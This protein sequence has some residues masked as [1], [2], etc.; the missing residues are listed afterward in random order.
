M[1]AQSFSGKLGGLLRGDKIIWIIVL[2]LSVFSVLTVYSSTE[3][4]AHRNNL[5]A[6]SFLFKHI[7]LL[8]LSIALMF[9]SHIVDHTRYARMSTYMILIAF[10]LLLITVFLGTSINQAAR[11]IRIPIIGLTFQ[12]SDFARLA[13]IVYT[14][15]TVA[16][17]QDES[18]PS[19]LG[20]LVIPVMLV[21][22]LIA[23]ADLSTSMILFFTCLLLMFIGRIEL[24]H[25]FSVLMLGI[26]AFALMISLANYFPAIR[27]DTWV[28]RLRGFVMGN[29]ETNEFASATSSYQVEQAQMAIAQGGFF[30]NGP[31]NGIQA[32][33]LPHSYSDYIYCVIVEEYGFIGAIVVLALYL[34]LLLRCIGLVTR[35]PR[36]FGAMLAFGLSLSIVLQALVHIAVN[37]NLLPVTGLTLPLISMGG[38]S[39]LFTGISLGIILSVSRYI[40]NSEEEQ[41]EA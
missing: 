39:L 31:G 37:V 16:L 36:A 6:E 35:S 21:C 33:F 27:R 10:F 7:L 2:L 18:K 26:G 4:L 23:P 1:N 34:L 20:E 3:A 40:E 8:G 15:R 17:M 9:V 30:G 14:A 29:A 25:V 11:W 38:T 13:L 24:R 32:H 41:E 12:T 19:S 22:G 5:A 28:S